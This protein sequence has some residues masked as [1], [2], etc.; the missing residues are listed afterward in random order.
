MLDHFLELTASQPLVQVLIVILATFVLEDAATVITAIQV[1][2]HTISIPHALMALYVG[3]VVGDVGLYALGALAARWPR[4]KRWMA[5]PPE[6]MQQTWLSKNL[7]WVVFISRF[8][9]GTRLPLYTA[10]GFFRAGLLVFTAATTCATLIWTTAL[11]LLSLRVGGVLLA[12]LGA[13]R[14][15]GVAGFIAVIILMGR[16]VARSQKRKM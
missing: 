2:L 3:I 14:W 9:P 15:V 13:W 7:F 8:V 10:C 1:H 6:Q 16:L 11:F 12:H 5:T 4:A